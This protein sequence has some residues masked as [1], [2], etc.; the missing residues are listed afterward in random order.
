MLKNCKL[1]LGN[2]SSGIIEGS[3]EYGSKY[4]RIRNI[5]PDDLV[6]DL[7]KLLTSG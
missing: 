5:Y 1:L 2:S 3:N 4:N 6:D 7:I